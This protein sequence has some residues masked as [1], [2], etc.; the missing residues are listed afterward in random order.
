[1]GMQANTDLY[2]RYP[3][4][5]KVRHH[6]KQYL[7]RSL[8]MYNL[9]VERK[10]EDKDINFAI[11]SVDVCGSV[12][13]RHVILCLALHH[14]CNMAA[15]VCYVHVRTAAALCLPRIRHHLLGHP[16]AVLA[17]C[18]L[19]QY[20]L[21][22]RQTRRTTRQSASTVDVMGDDDVFQ[23]PTQPEEAKAV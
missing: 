17:D 12:G 13:E 6:L 14:A 11:S 10:K 9:V 3:E 5:G 20:F 8:L 23:G 18:V 4:G 21:T 19:V 7:M 15:Q 2:F 22:P 1:M 16:S